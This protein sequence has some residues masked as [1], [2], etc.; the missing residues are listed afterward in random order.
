MAA[1]K[2]IILS[3][4]PGTLA[5]G[6]EVFV[7]DGAGG[8]DLYI[9]NSSNTPVLVSANQFVQSADVV[10]V[11][12]IVNNLTSTDTDKPLSANQGKV[13]NDTKANLNGSSTQSFNVQ[14][15]DY[16]GKISKIVSNVE[17]YVDVLLGIVSNDPEGIYILLGD[18]AQDVMLS[19][20]IYGTDSGSSVA[21]LR[22]PYLINI[23]NVVDTNQG[24]AGQRMSATII[25]PAVNVPDYEYVEVDYNTNRYRALKI[26]GHSGSF[27]P[28][29]YYFTGAIQDTAGFIPIIAESSEISNESPFQNEIQ[30]Q[31]TYI[32]D[33][34]VFKGDVDVQGT[35]KGNIE[36]SQINPPYTLQ[37]SDANTLIRIA[38]NGNITIP[39]QS[40]VQFPIGTTIAFSANAGV[41]AGGASIVGDTGVTVQSLNGA[42]SLENDY[43]SAAIVKVGNDLWRLSGNLV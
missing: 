40:S 7:E 41:T 22:G 33:K 43:A 32:S 26:A 19:G 24:T 14:N 3:S 6:T 8:L 30:T 12:D 29:Q 28:Q 23:V 42:N 39:P 21:S 37:L 2:R 15:L 31:A 5:E 13:L 35:L 4:V 10:E 1:I 34:N 17:R 27:Y 11:S 36:I 9:G 25:G 16:D 18:V 20:T 38:S